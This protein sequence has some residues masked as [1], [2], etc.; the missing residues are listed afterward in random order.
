MVWFHRSLYEWLKYWN[1][2]SFKG[3]VLPA[4]T[5]DKGAGWVIM[6][7]N[8]YRGQIV[9]KDLLCNVYKKVFINNNK[10]SI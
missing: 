3:T 9:E 4:V 6:D 8:Y 10:K 5:A 7:K 2:D 1:N